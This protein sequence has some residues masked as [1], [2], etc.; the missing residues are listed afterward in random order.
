MTL[1]SNDF[2]MNTLIQ[3]LV[4]VTLKL[5]L[6]QLGLC[7]PSQHPTEVIIFCDAHT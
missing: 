1:S 7:K 6:T 4:L 2:T 3:G 5:P